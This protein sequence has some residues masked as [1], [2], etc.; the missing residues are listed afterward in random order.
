[1]PIARETGYG[2]CHYDV[3]SRKTVTSDTRTK[4]PAVIALTEI[5]VIKAGMGGR[6]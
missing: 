3:V 4:M 2:F 5:N 6:K 1:M